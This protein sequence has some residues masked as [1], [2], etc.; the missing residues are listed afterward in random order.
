MQ[1]GKG[2]MHPFHSGREI[3]RECDGITPGV[4]RRSKTM[5][6]GITRNGKKLRGSEPPLES[7]RLNACWLPLEV[8]S[9]APAALPFARIHSC[10]WLVSRH[11]ASR[12]PMNNLKEILAITFG[13]GAG[14]VCGAKAIQGWLLLARA[15]HWQSTEGIIRESTLYKDPER[16]NATHF[17]IVYEFV[18]GGPI[19]GNTPRLSGNWFFN[20]K[21]Q[22]RFVERF[23]TGEVVTVYHD[24]AKPQVNCLDRDDKSGVVVY[25]IMSVG[26]LLLATAL[27]LLIR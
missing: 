20:L 8:A 6:A 15:R 7:L 12:L 14:L 21:Q 27:V 18:A 10:S 17:R 1:D 16:N 11:T 5:A 25:G 13:Y 9:S 24:A 23:K 22:Q 2:F 3:P 4:L 19:L 26:G